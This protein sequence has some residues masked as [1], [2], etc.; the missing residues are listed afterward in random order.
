MPE[1]P[2]LEYV[3][4][5][6]AKEL[7]GVEIRAVVLQKPVVLRVLLPEN[8]ERLVVGRKITGA[9]RRAHFVRFGLTGDPPLEMIVSPMLAGRFSI[10]KTGSKA[11]RDAAM[12]FDLDNGQTLFY[13]DDVQMGKVYILPK[14]AL[15]S[16]PGASKIG[17]D[18]LDPKAF[19]LK[20]FMQLAKSRRDQAK[21][22]LMDKSA[23]DAMGNAYADE[24]LF[25]ARIHPKTMVRRLGDEEIERLYKAIVNVLGAARKTIADRKP[26]ID[27]KIRDFLKVRGRPGEPCVHCGTK[28]RKAGV[29]GHDA[30]YC[31]ECQPDERKS[32]F[33]DFRK[34]KGG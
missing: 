27:E 19:T 9:A 10:A 21:V 4:P 5:I 29:H 32:A 7:V 17:V 16:V 23:L 18:V 6:L 14:D 25:E 13:R 1:R 22:F 8:V 11:P 15:D 34:V 24:V 33:V 3:V 30:I 12:G 31:P 26:P 28:L 2:D 20:M